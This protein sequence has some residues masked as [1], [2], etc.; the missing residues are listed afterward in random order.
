MGSKA[1][2]AAR[3]KKL[4]KLALVFVK[5]RTE[6]DYKD[7]TVQKLLLE[8]SA[9]GWL[10]TPEGFRPPADKRASVEQVAAIGTKRRLQALAAIGW[11]AA[12]VANETGIPEKTLRSARDDGRQQ[13]LVA[14]HIADA[15][16]E[17]FESE[18]QTP[19][20]RPQALSRQIAS[21]RRH[22]WY[23]PEAWAGLDIDD[24]AVQPFV[25]V[26]R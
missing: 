9:A 22:G 8:L 12:A 23:P 1:E 6:L 17:L 15:V 11:S 13:K 2:T 3:R 16:T 19:E 20:L 25:E 14:V 18:P 4:A 7:P 21:A 10:R 26:V 24:P 5:N